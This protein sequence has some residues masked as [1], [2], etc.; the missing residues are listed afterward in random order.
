MRGGRALAA[1]A[2]LGGLIAAAGLSIAAMPAL[3][4]NYPVASSPAEGETVVE[5]PGVVSLTT[6]DELLDLGDGASLDVLGSDG[7][8]YA[9]ECASLDG[10]TVSA[11]AALGEPGEYTVHWR[12]VSTDG[13]PISGEFAFDWQP[14]AGVELAEGL[15]EPACDALRGD[16][17]DIAGDCAHWVSTVQEIDPDMAIVIGITRT[18]LAADFRMNEVRRA[19]AGRLPPIPVFTIDARDREQASQLVRA[20]LLLIE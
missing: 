8:H 6:N 11:P 1:G 14:A 15:D 10:A 13:H 5:Q 19:L 9:S 17:A 3:A 2:L 16:A 20:L 18:D 7:R 4:H 12:V